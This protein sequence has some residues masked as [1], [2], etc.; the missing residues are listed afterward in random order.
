LDLRRTPTQGRVTHNDL[1]AEPLALRDTLERVAPDDPKC[2]LAFHQATLETVEPWY[3]ATNALDRAR[4]AE[5]S[6]LLA[7]EK[8]TADDPGSRVSRALFVG[9]R[10]DPDLARG[11]ADIGSMLALADEV[12]A[13]PG[14]F[15][16][17]L[18]YDG[19]DPPPVPAR[20]ELLALV[21]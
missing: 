10:S 16:K 2:A 13:R 11:L 9:A 17:V 4:L 7:G 21:S 8:P 14:L 5:I 19:A 15:E 1:R 3:R 12:L 18:E 20:E 6:A